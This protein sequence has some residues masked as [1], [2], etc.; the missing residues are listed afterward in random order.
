MSGV[1]KY[2]PRMKFNGTKLRQLRDGRGWSRRE[3]IERAGLGITIHTWANWEHGR[4]RPDDPAV[5]P[6]L[7][8]LFQVAARDLFLPDVSTRTADTEAA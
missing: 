4:T 6:A 5:I 2:S 1:R 7:A 3:A 8:D